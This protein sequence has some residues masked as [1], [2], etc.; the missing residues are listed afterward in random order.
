VAQIAAAKRNL[1]KARQVSAHR[2]RTLAQRAAS[3][4]NLTHRHRAH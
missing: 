1:I 3:K 4:R 2:P